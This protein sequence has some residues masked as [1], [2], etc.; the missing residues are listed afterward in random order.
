MA[1]DC[2]S[3]GSVCATSYSWTTGPHRGAMESPQTAAGTRDPATG[4]AY[5]VRGVGARLPTAKAKSFSDFS[6]DQDCTGR[7]G[8]RSYPC[9]ADETSLAPPRP[10]PL[11]LWPF[12]ASSPPLLDAYEGER[13]FAPATRAWC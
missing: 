4:Y 1:Q 11:P 13:G 3:V 12:R 2:W 7:G 8:T 10:A 6:H 5:G 9:P